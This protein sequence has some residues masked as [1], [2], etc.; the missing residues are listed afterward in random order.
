MVVM[1]VHQTKQVV[2]QVLLVEMLDLMELVVVEQVDIQME[3]LKSYSTLDLVVA[4]MHS[5][6]LKF[7]VRDSISQ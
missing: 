6:N 1:V 7:Q 3:R 4:L 2:D 5:Q